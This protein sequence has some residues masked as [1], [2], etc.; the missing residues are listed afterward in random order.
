MT[1]FS[2]SII[3][4]LTEIKLNQ[5]VIILGSPS[6]IIHTV[7]TLIP[8]KGIFLIAQTWINGQQIVMRTL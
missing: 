1:V 6:P 2:T 7:R 8:V 3:L 4:F 5:N